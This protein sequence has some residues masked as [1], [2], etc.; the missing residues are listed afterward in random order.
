VIR[1]TLG[2]SDQ[3]VV[4]A[5]DR[6]RGA[7]NA[8]LRRSVDESLLMLQRRI[9]QKLSGEVLNIRSGKLHGSVNVEQAAGEDVITGAVNAAAGPAWYGRVHEYGGKNAYDIYPKIKRALAF[10]G[11]GGPTGAAKRAFY[12]KQGAR[13]GSLRPKLYAAAATAGLV[14]VKSVHHPP[15][16]KRAFMSTSLEE[17]R[18]AIIAKVYRAAA[19]AIER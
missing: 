14:V 5:L 11:S 4:A 19:G 6:R 15:L 10:F 8:A 18:S 17:M 7:L 3:R 16:P 1:I 13:R 2:G 9:Q 12:F